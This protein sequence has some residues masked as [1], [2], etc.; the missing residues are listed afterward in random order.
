MADWQQKERTLPI[1]L[2]AISWI[3]RN[4]G[5]TAGRVLLP[6]VLLYYMLF[7]R[8]AKRH[9]RNYLRRVSG[10]ASL[11][12][13]FRHLYHFAAVTLDR[14][15]LLT[16]SSHKLQVTAEGYEWVHGKLDEGQGCL[17]LVSHVGSFEVMRVVGDEQGQIPLK[18]LLNREVSGKMLR[19]IEALNPEMADRIIDVADRGPEIVFSVQKA[20]EQGSLV[21]IMADR[22][23]SESEPTI[24]VPFLGTTTAFPKSPWLLAAATKVPVVVCF[25]WYLGGNRYHLEFTP[26]TERLRTDRRDREAG[27]R[28]ACEQYVQL[29]E[30][31]LKKHP[32]NWFNFYDFWRSEPPA[33]ALNNKANDSRVD[34]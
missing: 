33:T 29:L 2:Q 32:L 24:D 4:L 30:Q 7:A 6:F 19:I 10:H 15:V 25:G 9:S 23:F 21:G 8:V 13:V 14:V 27:L 28:A 34:S 18:I 5:R 1:F 12:D 11:A 17:M 31:G 26:L 3:V 22:V 16:G 20:L